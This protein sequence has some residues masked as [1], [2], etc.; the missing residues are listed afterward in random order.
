VWKYFEKRVENISSF[1]KEEVSLG[2]FCGFKIERTAI[3][4]Y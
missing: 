4:K 2:D 3:K 1:Q